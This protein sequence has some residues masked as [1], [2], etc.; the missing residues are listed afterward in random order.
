MARRGSKGGK[1]T[2]KSTMNNP[3]RVRG[4]RGGGR[5]KSR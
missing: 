4:P 2:I 5:K 3:L 1:T